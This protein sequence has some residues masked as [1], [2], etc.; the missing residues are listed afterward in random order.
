LW[1]RLNNCHC[2]LGKGRT[3]K[4]CIAQKT[5]K[6]KRLKLSEKRNRKLYFLE[7]IREFLPK[8]FQKTLGLYFSPFAFCNISRFVLYQLF[9]LFWI[10]LNNCH[11]FLEKGEP[12]NL[13]CFVLL[14][15]LLNNTRILSTMVFVLPSDPGCL[16]HGEGLPSAAHLCNLATATAPAPEAPFCFFLDLSFSLWGFGGSTLVFS[17]GY[18]IYLLIFSVNHYFIYRKLILYIPYSSDGIFILYLNLSH[19]GQKY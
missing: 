14:I 4:V 12:L 15:I 10:R 17:G 19:Y 5:P 6:N 7:I 16:R 11:S 1:K 3:W 2:F 8:Y 9:G 13:Y 18:Y